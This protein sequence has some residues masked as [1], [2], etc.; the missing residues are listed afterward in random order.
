[1]KTRLSAK[2]SPKLKN[3]LMER[4]SITLSLQ[5]D[6]HMLKEATEGLLMGNPV[7]KQGSGLFADSTVA[8]S[9]R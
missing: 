8:T 3:S 5:D 7:K 4:N 6:S 2:L 9:E 1:V